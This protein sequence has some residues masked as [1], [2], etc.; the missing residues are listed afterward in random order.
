MLI[1]LW[2]VVEWSENVTDK[3]MKTRALGQDLVL[4]R[5][6][7]GKAHCTANVCIHRGGSLANGWTEGGNVVCPY[8]GWQF[9]GDGRC[10][11]IPSE[12]KDFKIPEQFQIDSYPV[13]ERYGMVWAFLGDLPEEERYPIPEFPEY[14]DPGWRMIKSENTW[15]AEAARVV[16]NGIDLA[17]ASF[18]HPTFGYADTAGDN[19]IARMDVEEHTGVSTAVM[20]PPKLKGLRSG[21]RKDKEETRVHPRWALPGMVADIQIDL[22]EG[23]TIKMFDCNTPIDENTTRTFALQGRTFFKHWLF[24]RDSKKRLHKIFDED[25]EIVE[26]ASPY[27]LPERMVNEVSV[28]DDKFMSTF[29][30]ARRGLIRKGWQIDTDE[31]ERHRGKKVFTIPSPNRRKF[32][33][34]GKRWVFDEVPLVP[35]TEA[36]Q[37]AAE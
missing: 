15:K 3:P 2:Y 16:E 25:M 18:V 26:A 23:W 28:S 12:G 35:A 17:H 21:A 1:N 22:K 7:E 32:E 24:D 30:R 29:R 31:V 20:Y 33:N 34:S 9:G 10:K 5:D 19:Y 37:E 36:V 13:E 8:H 4:F 6:E 14:D 27:Y 11:L